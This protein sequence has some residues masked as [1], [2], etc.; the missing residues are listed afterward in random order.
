[1]R[2]YNNLNLRVFPLIPLR[3]KLLDF[4]GEEHGLGCFSK[5]NPS[6]FKVDSRVMLGDFFITFFLGEEGIRLT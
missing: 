5:N 1:M 4:G 6:S 3:I 2:K